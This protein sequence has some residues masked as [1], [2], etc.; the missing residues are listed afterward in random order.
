MQSGSIKVLTSSKGIPSNFQGRGWP[1][2]TPTHAHDIDD[3][4]PW[5]L[6]GQV[7]FVA[8]HGEPHPIDQ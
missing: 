1:V 5:R 6:L 2:S 3:A 8:H 4:P 7:S